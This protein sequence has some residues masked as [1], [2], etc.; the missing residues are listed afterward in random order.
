MG[1]ANIC[2]C[3]HT[4]SDHQQKSLVKEGEVIKKWRG[5]CEV[6][7][8][9]CPLYEFDRIHY[10]QQSFGEYGGKNR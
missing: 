6:D 5:E 1:L 3:G 10:G 4:M 8:C 9:N 7:I 2:K